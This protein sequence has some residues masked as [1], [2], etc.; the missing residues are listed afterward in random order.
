MWSHLRADG[1]VQVDESPPAGMSAVLTCAYMRTPALRGC[2]PPPPA[3]K[4]VSAVSAVVLTGNDLTVATTTV[5]D[6]LAAAQTSENSVR[7]GAPLVRATPKAEIRS[8]VT[9]PVDIA[10]IAPGS[11]ERDAFGRPAMSPDLVAF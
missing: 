2:F 10:A 6:A 8:A 4:V 9:F 7:A 11:S 1:I 5:A 3:P